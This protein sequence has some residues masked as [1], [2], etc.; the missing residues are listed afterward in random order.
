MMNAHRQWNTLEDNERILKYYP[1][2]SHP[3]PTAPIKKRGRTNI[4]VLSLKEEP[5]VEETYE[6]VIESSLLFEI[7]FSN[8][9]I[10]C[11]CLTFVSRIRIYYCFHELVLDYA[12]FL[13]DRT[14]SYS[15]IFLYCGRCDSGST[16][17]L[18]GIAE[19][20]SNDFNLLFFF[21]FFF[22]ECFF[23]ISVLFG[24]CLL[25]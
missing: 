14:N 3:N 11:L 1:G 17:K 25:N 24:Y 10:P 16:Q 13:M 18:M 6:Q 21:F 5:L 4:L 19:E 12:S 9:S 7:K 22:L 8:C 23:I 2:I 20:F 15:M